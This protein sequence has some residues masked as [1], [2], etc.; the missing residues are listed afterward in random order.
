[1]CFLFLVPNSYKWNCS[2]SHGQAIET[3]SCLISGNQVIPYF[4]FTLYPFSGKIAIINIKL[5]ISYKIWIVH[6]SYI[7]F[8]LYQKL[9]SLNLHALPQHFFNEKFNIIRDLSIILNSFFYLTYQMLHHVQLWQLQRLWTKPPNKPKPRITNC[10]KGCI[11][12]Y[13]LLYMSHVWTQFHRL[14][15]DRVQLKI[16]E[17]N[18]MRPFHVL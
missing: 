14:W 9:I 5:Q 18:C 1:M 4:K 2:C 11:M 16:D 8:T 17:N 15:D 7:M 12:S 6:T 13:H 10:L 3:V